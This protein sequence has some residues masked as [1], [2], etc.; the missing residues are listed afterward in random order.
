MMALPKNAQMK[1]TRSLFESHLTEVF[2][3]DVSTCQTSSVVPST[4]GHRPTSRWRQKF[5]ACFK[6]CQRKLELKFGKNYGQM[7]LSA[8]ATQRERQDTLGIMRACR[9]LNQEIS[10]CL[11]AEDTLDIAV[12]ISW[13]KWLYV[14][15]RRGGM[16][17]IANVRDPLRQ[18]FVNLPY[19]RLKKV[20][21]MIKAPRAGKQT[22]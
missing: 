12:S 8:S 14:R 9:Q 20:V 10:N 15:N 16:W 11:Y 4:D 3:L 2:F 1:R 6:Y 18:V 22:E 13:N 21:I 19:S 5:E 17:T 7:H